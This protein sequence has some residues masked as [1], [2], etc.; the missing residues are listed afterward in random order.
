MRIT[1]LRIRNFRSIRKLN[2]KLGK[3]TVLIGPNNS[4]KTA[5]LD[6]LRLILNRH[7]SKTTA[8]FH[9]DDVHRL[10]TTMS[11]RDCPPV[12]ISI[13]LI[14]SEYDPW[15]D[16][17]HL[18]LIDVIV[19]TDAGDSAIYL[20]LNISW[21]DDEQRFV[22]ER[23]FLNESGEV[24]NVK[25][26]QTQLHRLDEFLPSYSVPTLRNPQKEFELRSSH[27][28]RLLESIRISSNKE[29]QL[30]L[31][32]EQLDRDLFASDPRFQDLI[33]TLN[34]A[35]QVV[36]SGGRGK[37]RL[38]AMPVS[39][40]E[41]LRQT[42]VIMR[43]QLDQPWLPLI[44]HGQGLQSMT[45]L[46]LFQ[47]AL[48]ESIRS[49]GRSGVHGIFSVEEP[50]AHLHPHA[51]RSL[52]TLLDKS[53]SQ[54]IFTT[55]S[56]FFI[57]HMELNDI[58]LI[59]LRNSETICYS[60][61]TTS[62]SQIAWPWDHPTRKVGNTVF[63]EDHKSNIA[64]HSSFDEKSKLKLKNALLSATHSEQDDSTIMRFWRNCRT[65]VSADDL[66]AYLAV[67]KPVLGEALFAR[68]WILVEG[69]TDQLLVSA[70]ARAL[71]KSL[72]LYEVAVI[73]V[74]DLGI[75]VSVPVGI[76]IS[77]GIEWILVADN[78]QGG[79]EFR[80]HLEKR[81]FSKRE[82]EDNVLLH[83]FGNLEEELARKL[84][85]DLCHS[86]LQEANPN[87]ERLSDRTK[88]AKQFQ[89]CKVR[90]TSSLVRRLSRPDR[91]L[92]GAMPRQFRRAIDRMTEGPNDPRT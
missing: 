41:L 27:W 14:E 70:T 84:D 50:E 12:S 16:D 34:Q 2:I 22:P 42:T 79:I 53:D 74:S 89:D 23:H 51:V 82:L 57:Q 5:I 7:W 69:I 18:A 86:L 30:L 32:F 24:I 90:Y 17:V 83:E 63:F 55:H 6:A 85:L 35:T 19:E 26:L 87:Y 29:S 66:S 28:M 59:R 92:V 68:R 47:L 75:R 9:E 25:S 64:T 81:G 21:S 8:L 38:S 88:I 1:N 48:V 10:D 61:R 56:P 91:S 60:L 77:F 31:E 15:T 46:F 76:A 80:R 4:G 3:T 45:V 71:G 62:H 65:I 44:R 72:D 36:L 13:D 37:A 40:Q 67:G 11:P 20:R 49:A 52:W 54:K 33:K 78:D 73:A 58:R 39:V 43:N